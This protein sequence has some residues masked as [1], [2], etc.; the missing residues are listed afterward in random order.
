L[1]A[2]S[3]AAAVTG[4]RPAVTAIMQPAAK[5]RARLKTRGKHNMAFDMNTLGAGGEQSGTF[6][7]DALEVPNIRGAELTTH[8]SAQP[9]GRKPYGNVE[10]PCLWG[11]RQF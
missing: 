9:F 10:I 3:S 1:A 4:G 8:G 2:F 6:T 7:T 5:R 11:F